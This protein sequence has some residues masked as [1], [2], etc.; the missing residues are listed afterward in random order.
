MNNSSKITA[1]LPKIRNC[2]RRQQ[3]SFA[4]YAQINHHSVTR[5]LNCLIQHHSTR[6]QVRIKLNITSV[7]KVETKPKAP[8]KKPH[9]YY[10][11]NH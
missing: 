5:Q 8:N 9:Q 4:P 1:L 11:N 7:L 3:K 10:W 2:V 6:G